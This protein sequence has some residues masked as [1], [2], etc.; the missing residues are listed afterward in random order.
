MLIISIKIAPNRAIF[1][2]L[3]YKSNSLFALIGRTSTQTSRRRTHRRR[4]HKSQTQSSRVVFSVCEQKLRLSYSKHNSRELDWH[5]CKRDTSDS[6]ILCT[7]FTIP[8]GVYGQFRTW[9]ESR[10]LCGQIGRDK[11]GR[12]GLLPKLE[13]RPTWGLIYHVIEA[14]L[15]TQSNVKGWQ[16]ES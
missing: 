4:S 3:Q 2:A 7:Q 16:C 6:F 8:T 11:R 10:D 5:Q 15:D 14:A 12:Q 9:F 13:N 1:S